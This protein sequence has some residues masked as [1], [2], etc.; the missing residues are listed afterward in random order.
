[1][2]SNS[3][4][5]PSSL[6]GAE[7]S[8]ALRKFP[9]KMADSSSSSSSSSPSPP[10]SSSSSSPLPLTIGV[11]CLQGAFL[12]HLS[13]LRSLSPC[14]LYSLSLVEVRTPSSLSLCDGLILPG[15]ESTAISLLAERWNLLTPLRD[16]VVKENKPTFGT[17]AGAILMGSEVLGQKKGGQ[18]R[19]GGLDIT[20]HRNHYGTQIS[21]FQTRIKAPCLASIRS[22]GCVAVSDE[23]EAIFIRAPGI[24]RTG[25]GVEVLAEITIESTPTTSSAQIQPV[26]SDLLE[27]KDKSSSSSSSSVC[28]SMPVA[29]REGM[30]LATTFHPELTNHDSR[31]HQMFVEMVMEDKRKRMNN[32]N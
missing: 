21:S 29:V 15:G 27:E 24:L 3:L 7:I 16:W 10:P 4:P 2:G 13:S 23:C 12:E 18:E 31:W 14:P 20:I 28:V 11:L 9:R 8:K 5:A 32:R 30:I 17:C 25:P 6:F 19:I 22:C 1:V 26:A